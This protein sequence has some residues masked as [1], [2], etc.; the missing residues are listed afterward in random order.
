MN[1][2]FSD[3]EINKISEILDQKPEKADNSYMWK[4]VS[5]DNPKPLVF[6]IYTDVGLGKDTIGA[7]IAVQTRHGYYEL[8]NITGFMFFEPDEIIF[9]NSNEEYI[10]CLVI[11]KQ[12]SCSLFSNIRRELLN[13]DF[14]ELDPAVLLSAMQLSVTE[15][16]V[17]E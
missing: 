17:N 16:L 10:S 5:P 14:A 9:T 3:A 12:S 11:G 8:H 7:M 1:Y 6:T 4:L 13:A 15:D 2:K